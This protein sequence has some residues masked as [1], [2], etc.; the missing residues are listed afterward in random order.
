M[1]DENN[2]K[3]AFAKV[4]TDIFTLGNELLNLKTE[5]ISLKNQLDRLNSSM[6]SIKIELMQQKNTNFMQKTPTHI[7]T[8]VPKKPTYPAIPTDN[9]TH[10]VEIGGLKYPN[11]NISSG[12]VGV[13]TD[14]Q[15]NQQT[16]K[17]QVFYEEKPLKAQLDDARNILASLDAV[18]REIRLKFKQIT[19]QEMIVFSTIYQLESESPEGVEYRQI[20]NRLHLSESSIRDYVQKLINKGI[21][22]DKIKL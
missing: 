10:P 4:K 8:D 3:E 16:D 11:F 5:F 21:P 18:K 12:N 2:I 6:D 7:P 1:L 9:P 14:R 15:T 19:S 22:V 20:A 17:K 13:P